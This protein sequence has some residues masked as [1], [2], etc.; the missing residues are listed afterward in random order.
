MKRLVSDE[1]EP[2]KKRAKT[3][4]ISSSQNTQKFTNAEAIRTVLHAQ[5]SDVLTQGMNACM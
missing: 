1:Q 5:N 2:A 4:P 3:A